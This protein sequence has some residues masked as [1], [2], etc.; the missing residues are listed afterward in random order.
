MRE[1]KFT[2]YFENKVLLKSPYIKKEWCS[3]IIENPIKVE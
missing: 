3:R 1:Y 2:E